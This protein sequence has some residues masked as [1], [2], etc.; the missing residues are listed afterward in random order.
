MECDKLKTEYPDILFEE[1]CESCHQDD[2]MGWGEDLW[3]EIDGKDRNVC[4]AIYRAFE[5]D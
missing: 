5:E 3:F 1:C 4:C 2:E